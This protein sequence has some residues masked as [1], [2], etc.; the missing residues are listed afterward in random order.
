MSYSADVYECLDRIIGRHEKITETGCWIWSGA[1]NTAGYGQTQF[2]G[3]LRLVH[4][5]VHMCKSG[6]FPARSEVI[7]HTCDVPSCINPA[8]LK[9]GSQRENMYDMSNKGRAHWQASK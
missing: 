8:H 3:R 7:M 6:V 4:R 5:I 9:S 2:L 1:T